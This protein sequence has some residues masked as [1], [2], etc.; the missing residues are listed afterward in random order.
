MKNLILCITA[1]L[2]FAANANALMIDLAE[3]S[4]TPTADVITFSEYGLGEE[5]PEYIFGD[6]TVNF[7][8]YFEGGLGTPTNGVLAL[9]ANAAP[10]YITTDGANPTSPVLSG[11]PRFSGSI[12][13]LFSENVAAVG[14]DGGYFDAIGA[15]TIEAYDRSGNI[16]GAITNNQ[17]GIEFFGLGDDSGDAVIAGIQFYITG[18]EPAGYAIDNLTFAYDGGGYDGGGD[19]VPEPAT[20]LLMS[21]GLLGLVGYKRKRSNS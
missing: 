16:L 12:A 21:F 19:P 13:V 1:I 3:G 10:T 2:M 20:I 5:N 14:L 18:N 4:F 11:T 7:G 15:T 17:K 6:M 8:G 9:D